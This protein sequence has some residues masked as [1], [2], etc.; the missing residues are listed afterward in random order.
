MW[1]CF[2]L[3]NTINLERLSIELT[4]SLLPLGTR[5]NEVMRKGLL[6]PTTVPNSE[7][8]VSPLQQASEPE[9]NKDLIIVKYASKITR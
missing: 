9:N 7:A 2:Y 4:T 3:L 8:Q 6:P 5:R 1:K